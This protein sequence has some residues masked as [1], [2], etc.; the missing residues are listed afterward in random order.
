LNPSKQFLDL[1]PFKAP[2]WAAAQDGETIVV[3]TSWD[4]FHN[5]NLNTVLEENK[6][7]RVFVCGLITAVCVQNTCHGAFVRGYQVFLLED[8]CGDRSLERHKAAVLLYGDYMY[9][10]TSVLALSSQ[11][12]SV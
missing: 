11:E 12:T 3:K 4:G 5:T 2:S 6:I 7:R 10:S 8:A 9:K 1:D